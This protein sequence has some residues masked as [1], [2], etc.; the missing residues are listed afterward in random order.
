VRQK[1][2]IRDGTIETVK[3]AAIAGRAGLAARHVRMQLSAPGPT[4][5]V[6]QALTDARHTVSWLGRLSLERV[7][8]G[9]SFDL[10]H[11]ERVKSRHTVVQWRHRGC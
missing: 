1:S 10:W 4:D 3:A 11:D 5:R 6:W 9:G 8:E 7:A 2:P